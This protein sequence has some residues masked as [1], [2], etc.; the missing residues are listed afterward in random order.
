MLHL[1]RRFLLRMLY[2]MEPESS[3]VQETCLHIWYCLKDLPNGE[4][5]ALMRQVP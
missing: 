5:F 3:I 1:M 4:M 2:R